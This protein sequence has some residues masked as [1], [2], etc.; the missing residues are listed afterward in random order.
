[1]IETKGKFNEFN[2]N[3]GDRRSEIKDYN[4]TINYRGFKIIRNGYVVNGGADRY[5][6]P[7]L[8]HITLGGV[9]EGFSTVSIIQSKEAIDKWF[10]FNQELTKL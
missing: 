2:R 9:K 8:K 10:E 5:E 7:T 1:M 6:V 4:R 3:T